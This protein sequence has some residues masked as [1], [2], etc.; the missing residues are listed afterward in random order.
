LDKRADRAL[1][2]Q[3]VAEIEP[4]IK[5]NKFNAIN[6]FSLLQELMD[7]TLVAG[8]LG[9]IGRLLEEF[10]FRQALTRLHRTV[11]SQRWQ[12]ATHG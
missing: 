3:L 4:L 5:H 10:R 9:Q 1:A 8:E 6:H 11:A 7:G 12:E 2:L